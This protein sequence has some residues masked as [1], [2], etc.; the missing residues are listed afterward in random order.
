[1]PG[2]SG[3]G[4]PQ[5]VVCWTPSRGTPTASARRSSPPTAGPWPRPAPTGRCG[6]GTWR[7][8]VRSTSSRAMSARC[9][10]WRSPRT[11][12]CWPPPATTATCGSG[13]WPRTQGGPRTSRILHGRAG[14][15]ALAFSPDGR[16][17]AAADKR[18]DITFWDVASGNPIR[19][20]HADRDELRGLAFS[21]DGQTLAVAG[22]SGMIRLWDFTTGQELLDPRGPQAADQRPG[23]RPRRPD[24]RLV[25][26]RRCGQALERSASGERDRPGR[27]SLSDSRGL[28]RSNASRHRVP[29]DL[30]LLELEADRQA[31]LEDPGGEVGRVDLAEGG[32]EEDGAA[33]GQAMGA[34]DCRRPS[35]SRRGRRGRT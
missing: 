34:D 14:F 12:G 35:R 19:V 4:I 26:S 25:Q 22:V 24:P 5:P 31:G 17:L 16:T 27:E 13:T 1:M 11:A 23:L 29:E 7:L 18:G 2:M 8:A 30:V 33:V 21:P 32:A 6:S 15:Q 9:T 28:P 3:S 10:P 20:I